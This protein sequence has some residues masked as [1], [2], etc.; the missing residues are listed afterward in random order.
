MSIARAALLWHAVSRSG[1]RGVDCPACAV[2]SSTAGPSCVPTWR[3]QS[4]S[5]VL[6]RDAYTMWHRLTSYTCHT[7]ARR[8]SGLSRSRMCVLVNRGGSIVVW[9][10]VSSWDDRIVLWLFML[11]R[12]C[13]PL[14]S[15]G[16][17]GY[18][19][20]RS[21]RSKHREGCLASVSLSL[22]AVCCHG[23]P[24]IASNVGPF[25]LPHHLQTRSVS[26]PPWLAQP[27]SSCLADTCAFM[28]ALAASQRHRISA[29]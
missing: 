23:T 28:P 3:L 15:D 10:C 9:I 20:Q 11:G 4:A 5:L 2:V 1:L 26:P 24:N 7:D 19:G 14:T 16:F 27:P 29:P 6:R 25:R 18:R 13:S 22:N 12:T 8:L 17:L 21:A